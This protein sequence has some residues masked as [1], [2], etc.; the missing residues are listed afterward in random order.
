MNK[1]SP[2]FTIVLATEET[3]TP[4]IYIDNDERMECTCEKIENTLVCTLDD[5]KMP[6]N[7]EYE[8]YYKNNCGVLVKT[9]VTV[10][11]TKEEIQIETGSSYISMTPML[12]GGLLLMLL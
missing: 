9:G 2:T 4:N 10:S 12:I 1:E 6:E 3:E 8:I 5:N 11:Y 7:K